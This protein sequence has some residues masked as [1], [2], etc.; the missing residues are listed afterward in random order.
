[1]K[2]PMD[3]KTIGLALEPA[4]LLGRGPPM[5]ETLPQPPVRPP[6]Q[7][8]FGAP[9]RASLSELRENRAPVPAG[10]AQATT[11]ASTPFRC[12]SVALRMRLWSMC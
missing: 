8:I 9:K 6:Q 1:M 4:F 3:Q 11:G 7:A 12:P 2:V 5:D 10:L